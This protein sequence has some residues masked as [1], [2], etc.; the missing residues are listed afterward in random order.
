MDKKDPKYESLKSKLLKLSSLAD[1]CDTHEA[2]N[3]RYAIEHLCSK[4]GISIEEITSEV[5]ESK[6]YDFEVGRSKVMLS[7]FAQCYFSVT[8]KNRFNYRQIPGRSKV[9]VNLTS[10]EYAELKSM[11]AWHKSNYNAE[12]K[13][14]EDTLFHAYIHKHGLFG[15]HSDDDGKD[16]EETKL[17]PELLERIRRII[18]MK[19]TLSDTH[20]HKMIEQ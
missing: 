8:G 9:G 1:S 5:Q 13:K 6:W 7:L 2:R 18:H 10:F 19:Q 17:T 4:Y 3:A 14:M 11:F 16:K 20:Y 15:A 12:H